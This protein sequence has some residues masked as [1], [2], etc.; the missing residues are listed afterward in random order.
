MNNV[1][2][3]IKKNSSTNSLIS[4]T[5]NL[6]TGEIVYKLRPKDKDALL[7]EIKNIK[8]INEASLLIY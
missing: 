8:G 1:L 3:V 4:Q 5:S 2:E 7:Q 6:D